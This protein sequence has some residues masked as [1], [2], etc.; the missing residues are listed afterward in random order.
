MKTEDKGSNI[1]TSQLIAYAQGLLSPKGMEIT[2]RAIG[3]DDDLAAEYQGILVLLELYPNEDPEEILERKAIKFKAAFEERL[4]NPHAGLKQE[5]DQHVNGRIIS[6]FRNWKVIAAAAS[7]AV[8][9][10][11]AFYLNNRTNDSR[12]E[13][14]LQ[15]LKDAVPAPE[16]STGQVYSGIDPGQ[17]ASDPWALNYKSKNYEDVVNEL[18]SDV[19]RDEVE[20]FYLALSYLY[21]DPPA[22]DKAIP[23]FGNSIYSKLYSSEAW[24]Y[25]GIAHLLKNDTTAALE[26]LSKSQEIEA[27]DLIEKLHSDQS[28]H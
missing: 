28:T 18:E 13:L 15:Y 2:R 5:N 26:N 9:I 24:L 1:D 25:L 4:S 10:G 27:A 21:I 6:I 16:P 7:I 3:K 11:V 23:L 22:P 20:T 19:S 14:A 12:N 17:H 8:L